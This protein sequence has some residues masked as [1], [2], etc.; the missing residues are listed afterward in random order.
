MSHS[1]WKHSGSSW[2]RYTHSLTPRLEFQ[3]PPPPPRKKSAAVARVLRPHAVGRGSRAASDVQLWEDPVPP[4]AFFPFPQRGHGRDQDAGSYWGAE[5]QGGLRPPPRRPG[6]MLLG[7]PTKC[8][9]LVQLVSLILASADGAVSQNSGVAPR[10]CGS[11]WGILTLLGRGRGRACAV[12]PETNSEAKRG[13]RG[14]GQGCIKT[15]DNRRRRGGEGAPPLD[16]PSSPWT[17]V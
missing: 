15:A 6:P 12:Q 4:F 8:W 11:I 7:V 10:W 16:P 3:R 13:G 17:Q 1:L 14:R 5:G 2:R 9:R